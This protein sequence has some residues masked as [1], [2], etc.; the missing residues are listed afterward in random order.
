[1]RSNIPDNIKTSSYSLEPDGLV[2]M[3]VLTLTNGTIFRMHPKVTT[4]WQGNIYD[5]VT[6]NLT[7]MQLES[8]GKSN[9]PNFTFVN[10]EGVFTS[11]IYGRLLDNA[12]LTRIR[13]L[14]DDLINNRN[15]CIT[16]TMVI[17]QILSVGKGLVT[18]QLRDVHDGQN[19]MLP[20]GAYYPPEFPH[21]QLR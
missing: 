12:E 3:F 21:V 10:P 7:E 17:K 14:R 8:D 19:F 16:E 6:C 9:R 13:I 1:M 15:F 11:Y 4:T 5:F 18:A 20:A 2:S